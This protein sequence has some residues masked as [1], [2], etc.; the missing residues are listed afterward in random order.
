[1]GEGEGVAWQGRVV[2]PGNIVS[3][4]RCVL[5]QYVRV[6]ALTPVLDMFIVWP[7]GMWA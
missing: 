6:F 5:C 4:S 7:R 3:H 1:M 2:K